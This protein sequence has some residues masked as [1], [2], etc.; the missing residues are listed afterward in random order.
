M[1]NYY[2]I[3]E[4]TKTASKEE[5]KKAYRL[6]AVKY[7]PDKHNGDDYFVHKFLEV[8]ESYEILIDPIK[9]EEYDIKYSKYFSENGHTENKKKEESYSQEKSKEK[10]QEEEFFY[11]PHKPFY[12]ERDRNQNET[13]Q[14]EPIVDHWGNKLD[15]EVDFFKLPTKIGKIISGY[16][17][18]YKSQKP[19]SGTSKFKRYAICILIAI[20]ISTGII[21]GIGVQSTVWIFIWAV[22]PL[23]LMIWIADANVQFKH[24]NT[25]IGVNGF[26]RFTCENSRENITESYE[27]NFNDVTDLLKVTQINKRNFNYTGTDYGFVWLKNGKLVREV[28]GSHQSKE[29]KPDKWQDEF[30]VNEIAERY[31]TVYLLDNMEK[32]L[33]SKGYIE[34]NLI[35][36][37]NGSY[38]SVPYIRLGIGYIEFI[39][40]KENFKYN[41]NDIKSVHTKGSNLFIEHKNYQKKFYFFK[42]GN[43]NG[44]PLRNLSNYQYFFRSFELLLGYKF[45]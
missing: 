17:S 42:S 45:D 21:F 33:E 14:F 23:A 18:L 13:P 12:S 29:G 34:F 5:I 25:F 32:D 41:F 15:P 35:G 6:K 22:A 1:K 43:K 37:S 30:W 3:L 8:Q 36:Y 10:E 9:R 20:A 44:I 4:I 27:I 38:E 7:H 31:W 28:N 26:A 39:N 2:S 11:N 40:S 24:Y 16:S 19:I